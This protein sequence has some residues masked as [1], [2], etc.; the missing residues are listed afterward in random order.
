MYKEIIYFDNKR[1]W[2]D[3]ARLNVAIAKDLADSFGGITVDFLKRLNRK[4]KMKIAADY[5]CPQ[6]PTTETTRKSLHRQHTP[7]G[8]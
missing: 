6:T 2:R 7:S 3:K 8:G 5:P 4:L 1:P